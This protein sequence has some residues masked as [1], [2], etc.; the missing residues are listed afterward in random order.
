MSNIENIFSDRR[1]KEQELKLTYS[2]YIFNSHLIMFL[3][4][5]LGAVLI[6]YSK[7][8]VI[9]SKVELYS[10]LIAA[11]LAFSYYLV[12]SKIKTHIK[13]ADAVFLLP[14]EKHYRK[15]GLKTVINSTVVHIITVIIFYFATKPITNLIGNIDRLSIIMLLIVI[16][17]N[18]LLK[19]LQV[20]HYKEVVWSKL[21]LFVVIFMQL[22]VI[23]FDDIAIR[24]IYLIS[25]IVLAAFTYYIMKNAGN[26]LNAKDQEKYVVNWNQAADYDKHRIESYLKFVNMF[27]DVPLSGVKVARRKY[28]DI[29]LP[30]LTKDNFKKENSFKYYYYRVFLRQENTVYLALRLMLLAALVIFSFKNTYVSGLAIISYSY[31][32]IIQLVPLYKQMSNNIWHS[33]LPVSE[34]IKI[35]SYKQLLTSVIIVTT[36]LLGVVSILLASFST[37][38]ILVI[39]GSVV[40]A[41]II[42]KIF[43]GKVK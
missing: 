24:I 3:I 29:L 9:A 12:S 8:L 22:L 42:S 11:T 38:N 17:W 21:L 28:F 31:L 13:E 10:V 23:F 25:I 34:D 36:L 39:I 26:K 16:I 14:L 18:N 15:V 2:K 4:I 20:I 37:M 30:K 43:I 1:K 27:V 5:V 40:I 32:T 6:N 33:I 7:W 19:Y 41:N 35:K